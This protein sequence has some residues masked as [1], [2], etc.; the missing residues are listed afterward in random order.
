MNTTILAYRIRKYSSSIIWLKALI[1]IT[2]Q[3]D[4]KQV[5][6]SHTAIGHY[7][8]SRRRMVLLGEGIGN[9]NAAYCNFDRGDNERA[10]C[11]LVQISTLE[12]CGTFNLKL[13]E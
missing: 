2:V 8:F 5:R 10:Q 9:Q 13:E 6:K 3:R 1:E 4:G 12:V 11:Q 7:K